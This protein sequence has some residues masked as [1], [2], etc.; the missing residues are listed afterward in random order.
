MGINFSK[1]FNI[2]VNVTGP[3]YNKKVL[4]SFADANLHPAAEAAVAE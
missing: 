3:N 2:P 4:S 1:Y